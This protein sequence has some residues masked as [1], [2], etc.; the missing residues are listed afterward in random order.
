MIPFIGWGAGAKRLADLS[1]LAAKACKRNSFVAGTAVLLA[2]GLTKAIEDIEVGD[3][4]LATDPATGI[5]EPREVTALIVGEG[6][7]HLVDI[8]VDTDGDAG[9]KTGTLIAT[10]GHPFWV[11]NRHQWVQAEQLRLGDTLRSP[12][13]TTVSVDATWRYTQPERV[14][15]LTVDD[16]HTYYVVAGNTP[17][18]VHNDD[19]GMI[20]AG[21]TQITS[22]T[23]WLR[24]PY[25]ID[26]ENPNPGQRPGQI[27]FQDQATGA[28][29]MYNF[30]TGEFDGMPNSLKKDLSKNFSDYTKGITKGKTALGFTGC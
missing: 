17:V 24:G 7:K 28:K 3:T 15:N 25:R 29:Y 21:G 1:Q 22:K 9:D 16:I 23:L 5:T 20:G 13:Q 19:G 8:T 6:D 10:E 14:Y 26:I 18:L 11:E 2:S 12:N 30:E 4:V 27:H